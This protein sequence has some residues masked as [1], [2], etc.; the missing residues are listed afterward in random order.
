MPLPVYSQNFPFNKS[1]HLIQYDCV[2]RKRNCVV[3][4]LWALAPAVPYLWP[5][6]VTSIKSPA[7]WPLPIPP[8]ALYTNG[9]PLQADTPMDVLVNTRINMPAS[10]AP[11]EGLNLWRVAAKLSS[12]GWDFRRCC[13]HRSPMDMETREIWKVGGLYR[14]SPSQNVGRVGSM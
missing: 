8:R 12:S 7:A 14:H 4:I 13:T 6:G 11:T 10:G 2:L 1:Q 9:S 3:T 5:A